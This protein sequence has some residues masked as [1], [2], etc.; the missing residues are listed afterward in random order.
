M[1]LLVSVL[2]QASGAVTLPPVAPWAVEYA[3]NM[4]VLSRGFGGTASAPAVSLA[5]RPLPLST[6]AEMVVAVPTAGPAL[7]SKGTVAVSLLPS[8]ERREVPFDRWRNATTGRTIMSFDVPSELLEAMRTAQAI[9]FAPKREPTVKLATT[10]TAKALTALEPCQNDLLRTWGYD[11]AFKDRMGTP[12]STV[13]GSL[14]SWFAYQYYPREAL[15]NGQQGRVTIAWTIDQ[16]GKTRDC[17]VLDSSGATSLDLTT[18]A[19]ILQKARF[20][21]ALDKDGK[22]MESY[23]VQAIRWSLNP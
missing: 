6:R 19:I 9:E 18:C 1:G 4:C 13:G 15:R 11:P 21:P 17:R 12:A 2:I 3:P 10:G 7:A 20:R 23:Q 22:P 8:G 14:G 5:L 16:V